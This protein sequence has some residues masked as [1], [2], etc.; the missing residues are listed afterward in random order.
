[1]MRACHR[2]RSGFTL[3]ELMLVIVIIG[4]L[5]AMV[6]PRLVNRLKGSQ[7][8]IARADIKGNLSLALRLYAVDNNGMYP[9]TEQGLAAL[10]TKPSSPPVPMNWKGPYLEQKYLDP[11][12]HPYAYRY[13]GSH[14]PMEYDLSSLG[15]DGK[16]SDDDISNWQD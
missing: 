9:S 4:S 1:M 5:A 11:W 12:K 2:D 3:I 8:D 6:V 14:P 10:I 7:E 15:A 13:P 16:E